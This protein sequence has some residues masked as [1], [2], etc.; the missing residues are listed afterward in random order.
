MF[1]N[2][3]RMTKQNI[4]YSCCLWQQQQQVQRAIN[5][6][7]E[8]DMTMRVWVCVCASVCR[9][10][11]KQVREKE[12]E[13]QRWGHD[14][15]TGNDRSNRKTFQAVKKSIKSQPFAK[16]NQ[17][18][19]SSCQFSIWDEYLEWNWLTRK[20][21]SLSLIS[22]CLFH[23][24]TLTHQGTHSLSHT[25]LLF[26]DMSRD[27]IHESIRKKKSYAKPKSHDMW[28]FSLLLLLLLLLSAFSGLLLFI[29]FLNNNIWAG[30]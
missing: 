14:T 20:A 9:V 24:H 8:L 22:V 13:S 27:S 1:E 17:T 10:H 18:N 21:K 3:F 12:R 26:K 2:K 19:N 28:H 5:F 6:F 16:P 15:Q 7:I 30:C 25:H 4:F 23:T 29:V 11:L